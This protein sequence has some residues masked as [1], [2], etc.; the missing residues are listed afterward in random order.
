[1]HVL[2]SALRPSGLRPAWSASIGP[3]HADRYC[4]EH[5]RALTA[6][7][8]AMSLARLRYALISRHHQETQRACAAD[9]TSQTVADPVGGLLPPRR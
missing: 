7:M 4:A 9:P 2:S 3:E 6:I 8:W 5:G 1:M